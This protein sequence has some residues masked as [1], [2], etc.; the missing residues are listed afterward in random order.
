MAAG[1]A[2]TRTHDC[3]R[4]ADDWH[5]QADDAAGG[6]EG[7]EAAD[8]A[9]AGIAPWVGDDLNKLDVSGFTTKELTSIKAALGGKHGKGGRRRKGGGKH[10]TGGGKTDLA[11]GFSFPIGPRGNCL[12]ALQPMAAST[13]PIG[14]RSN[15]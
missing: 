8:A 14:R 4:L 2:Y 15:Y 9:I 5:W 11:F 10:G 1:E 3:Q 7:G 12:P 6:G 13:I